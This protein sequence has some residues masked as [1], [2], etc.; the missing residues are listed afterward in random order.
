MCKMGTM[1][2]PL[3][4]IIEVVRPARD[5]FG[6]ARVRLECGPEGPASNGAIYKARCRK[7]LTSV[8]SSVNPPPAAH[9]CPPNPA[10]SSPTPLTRPID[11]NLSEIDHVVPGRTL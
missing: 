9:P 11:A 8:S 1:K 3:R 10:C 5:L 6:S 2:G 7:R 4:R